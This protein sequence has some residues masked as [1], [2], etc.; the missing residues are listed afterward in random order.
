MSVPKSTNPLGVAQPDRSGAETF[1][2][3][4]YQYHWALCKILDR[5]LEEKDYVI[6]VEF[7]EDVLYSTS[8]VE[9]EAEFEFTQV[10]AYSGSPW[11]HKT[12]TKIKKGKTRSTLG[13]MLE[14]IKGKPFEKNIISLELAGSAGFKFPQKD[15]NLKLSSIRLEDITD[16]C[17][18]EIKSAIE[19]EIG[20]S[21]LPKNLVFVKPNLIPGSER[22]EAITKISDLISKKTP[23]I[24]YDSTNIYRILI[25]DLHMK[26]QINYDFTEW[27]KLIKSKGTTYRAVDEVMKNYSSQNT[28]E[29]LKPFLEDFLNDFNFPAHKKI[30]IRRAFGRYYNDK[31]LNREVYTLEKQVAI[32]ELVKNNY[33]L[34]LANGV[35]EFM[36][37]CVPIL[38]AKEFYQ[39]I[40]DEIITAE[41]LCE[42]SFKCYE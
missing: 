27:D 18:I 12:I 7:H 1:S 41:L 37:T 35:H 30:A 39:S 32:E 24:F 15:A 28:L 38:K 23:G 36:K 2:K 25:D 34:F 3:Y 6:F 13:R 10:K 42:L 31:K 5:H 29:D 20:L 22:S 33:K 16:D 4:E 26:G 21:E 17:I 11:N 40:D 19:K 9:A 8:S 14:G